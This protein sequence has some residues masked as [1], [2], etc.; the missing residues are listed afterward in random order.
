M[1]FFLSLS[2]LKNKARNKPGFQVPDIYQPAFTKEWLV[3]DIL[4][5]A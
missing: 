1:Q 4:D 5:I 2:P 3:S